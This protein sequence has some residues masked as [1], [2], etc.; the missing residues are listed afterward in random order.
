MECEIYA[1]PRGYEVQ[2]YHRGELIFSHR[3][4]TPELAEAEADELKC[5][6]LA[7]G[8]AGPPPMPR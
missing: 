4:E 3:H 2:V 1:H 8:W 6:R 5:D 7:D